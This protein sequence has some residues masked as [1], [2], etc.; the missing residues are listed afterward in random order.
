MNHVLKNKASFYQL[1]DEFGLE[2]FY[3][4]DY[5]IASIYEVAR[6]AERFLR[7][8]EDVYKKAGVAE[9]YPLGVMLRAA[10]E[11][12][13][14]GGC[15]AYENAGGRIGGTRGDA[16]HAQYFTTGQEAMPMV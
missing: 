1:V 10:E 12:G 11:D 4:P 13:N 8:V 3:P 9:A 2:G 16:D 6:E 15:V 5:T 7:R 14:Y